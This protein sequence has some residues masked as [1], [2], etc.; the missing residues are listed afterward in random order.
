MFEGCLLWIAQLTPFRPSASRPGCSRR[1]CQTSLS[2]LKAAG[3]WLRDGQIRRADQQESC[4]R[5]RHASHRRAFHG[6][7]RRIL[8]VSSSVAVR[9]RTCLGNENR[10]QLCGERREGKHRFRQQHGHR[11]G[12]AEV[13][14]AGFEEHGARVLVV[15]FQCIGRQR[16][17]HCHQEAECECFF[18]FLTTPTVHE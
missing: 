7:L 2:A 9:R 5:F 15:D 6:S 10:N 4:V 12:R 18:G 13:V 17:D 11:T 1:C 8:Q 3:R 16:G 14:Q